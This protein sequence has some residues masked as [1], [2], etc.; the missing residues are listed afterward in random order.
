[1][2]SGEVGFSLFL[3]YLWV[4]GLVWMLLLLG[5]KTYWC[6]FFNDLWMM[7]VGNANVFYI[8]ATFER[9]DSS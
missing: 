2:M 9:I 6:C 1:M 5:Y 4:T 7:D 8:F 3:S